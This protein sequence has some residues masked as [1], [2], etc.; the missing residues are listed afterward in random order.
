M[1]T[2]ENV[3]KRGRTVW[4]RWLLPDLFRYGASALV[5]D[6]ERQL[7]HF[8]TGRYSAAYRQPMP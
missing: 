8:T 6:I 3:L 7:E 2:M 1:I 4:D 5:T